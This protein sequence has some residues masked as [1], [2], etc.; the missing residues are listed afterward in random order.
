MCHS[1]ADATMA[2][3]SCRCEIASQGDR[4]FRAIT[5]DVGG[6]R[7]G[8]RRAGGDPR[9]ADRA[10]GHRAWSPVPP[11]AALVPE[12]EAVDEWLTTNSLWWLMLAPA[13][14]LR[15]Q[16]LVER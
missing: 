2:R 14:Q 1:I 6:A 7:G 11:L 10:L 9:A 15:G 5:S 4:D 13:D 8:V 3:V 16:A 12:T